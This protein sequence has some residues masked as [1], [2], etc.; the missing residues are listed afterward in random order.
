MSRPKLSNMRGAY[1]AEELA[2]VIKGKHGSTQQKTMA[3]RYFVDGLMLAEISEEQS[4][5]PQG[6]QNSMRRLVAKFSD[7]ECKEQ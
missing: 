1:S 3:E 2:E 4:M 7:E 5:T 6:V